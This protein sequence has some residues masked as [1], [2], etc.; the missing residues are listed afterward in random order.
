MAVGSQPRVREKSE[1]LCQII[2][3][4]R[5]SMKNGEPTMFYCQFFCD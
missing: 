3:N 5:F 1:E 2:I 4:L